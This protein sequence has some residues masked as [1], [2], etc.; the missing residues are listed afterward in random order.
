MDLDFSVMGEVR[1]TMVDYLKRVIADFPEDI[2]K[3]SPTPTG[4]HMFEVFPDKEN[5]I[6]DK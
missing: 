2:M 3:I 5:N 1:V 6:L 4:D